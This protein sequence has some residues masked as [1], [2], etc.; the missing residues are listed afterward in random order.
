MGVKAFG[1]RMALE[2]E[3]RERVEARLGMAF[4]EGTPFLM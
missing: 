4:L 1:T 2:H 3:G